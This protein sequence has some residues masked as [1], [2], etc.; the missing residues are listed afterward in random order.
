M[1]KEKQKKIV[2]IVLGLGVLAV[3]GLFSYKIFNREIRLNEIRDSAFSIYLQNKQKNFEESTDWYEVKIKYPEQN[4]RSADFIFKMWNDFANENQLKKYKSL[5]EAKK[6]LGLNVDGAKY[7]FTADYKLVEGKTITGSSTISYVYTVYTFT[8]GAHGSTQI[9]AF[10]Q[11]EFGKVIAIEDILPTDKLEKISKIAY[12]ELQ[13]Q[14]Q[15]RLKE[16]KLSD[17]EIAETM[18]DDSWLKEG[19]AATRDNYNVAWLD[20]SDTIISFG[21]YQIASYAE[22]IFEIKIPL[23]EI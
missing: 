19:T 21:Q 8:G 13:K 23:S 2:L 6:E 14:R 10:T 1:T 20:G 17:K 15:T 7:G 22:G 11:D 3:T 4:S 5:A 12:T 16:F 18:K 9:F